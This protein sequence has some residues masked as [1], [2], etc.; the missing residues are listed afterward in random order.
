MNSF[1]VILKLDIG[2][3]NFETDLILEKKYYSS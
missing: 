2:W 1:G 3:D